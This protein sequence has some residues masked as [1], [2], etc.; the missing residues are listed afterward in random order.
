MFILR[1]ISKSGR[2]VEDLEPG[3]FISWIRIHVKM[4]WILSTE[5]KF[6]STLPPFPGKHFMLQG[7]FMQN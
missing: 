2:N 5:N 6:F 3:P 7:V 1:K 4:K